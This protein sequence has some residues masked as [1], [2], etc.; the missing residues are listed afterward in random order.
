LGITKDLLK[1][2]QRLCIQSLE[3]EEQFQHLKN[4]FT[5]APILKIVE[6]HEDFIV[7]TDACKE[8]LR[9]VLIQ[10]G[11]VICYESRKLKKHER[12]YATH[13]S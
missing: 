12:R 13:D 7:C 8:G 5:S 11:N 2:F 1:A 10:N 4:S 9:G 6:P 3:S